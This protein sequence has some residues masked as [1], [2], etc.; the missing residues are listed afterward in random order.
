MMLLTD[1]SVVVALSCRPSKVKN[2]IY[3]SMVSDL[4]ILHGSAKD[5]INTS[6][7]IGPWPLRARGLIVLASSN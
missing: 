3:I 6:W 4:I 5:L 7:A 1:I 2:Y